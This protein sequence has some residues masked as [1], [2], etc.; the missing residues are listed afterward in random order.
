QIPRR[1][2]QAPGVTC[3]TAPLNTC[4]FWQEKRYNP[5]HERAT[6]TSS[7]GIVLRVGRDAGGGRAGLQVDL[8][9]AHHADFQIAQSIQLHGVP[10]RGCGFEELYPAFE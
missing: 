10:S 4:S 7:S 1:P 3:K 8:R 9:A 5:P 2:E 6:C